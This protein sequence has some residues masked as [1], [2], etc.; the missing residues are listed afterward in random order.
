VKKTPDAIFLV[1][2]RKDLGSVHEAVRTGV[3][4]VAITDT[5]VNPVPVDFGV[6]ANDDAVG[7]IK[8]IIDYLVEAWMEGIVENK[9]SKT[10]T[11]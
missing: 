10:I 1:D 3:K 9:D 2:I 5:N 6:P 8:I 7:S 11:Q 4:I